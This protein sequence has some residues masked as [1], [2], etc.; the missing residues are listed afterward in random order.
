MPM[1]DINDANITDNKVAKF[2][3]TSNY[4][5][6]N[7]GAQSRRCWFDNLKIFRYPSNADGPHFEY[8]VTPGVKGDVNGDEKMD[9]SDVVAIINTMA[10]DTTFAATADVNGDGEVNIS[11][12]VKV[13]NIMA[14]TEE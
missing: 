12:V 11:D 13:I 14:G 6:A 7:S 10:G 1:L 5:S 9:I 2:V 4:K 3:I 8:N